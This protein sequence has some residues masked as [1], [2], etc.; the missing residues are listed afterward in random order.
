MSTFKGIKP[1]DRVA[2]VGNNGVVR[3]GHAQLHGTFVHHVVVVTPYNT[4]CAV[5]AENYREH[6]GPG[7]LMGGWPV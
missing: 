2:F 6:R 1:L 4:H 5:T 7:A 3:W